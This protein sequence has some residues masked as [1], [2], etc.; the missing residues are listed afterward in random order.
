VKQL[1][2]L[3]HAK[4]SAESPQGTDFDRPLNEDGI[5]AAQFMGK[6]LA[7][8]QELPDLVCCSDS[9]RTRQTLLFV[10]DQLKRSLPVSYQNGLYLASAGD[11]LDYVTAI[12]EAANTVMLIGHNPGIYH[13][14]RILCESGDA[15]SMEALAVKF[16]TCAL[17]WIRFPDEVKWSHVA[18]N[19]G[20][21][22]A[23]WRPKILMRDK[24]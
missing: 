18:P 19:S 1:L 4:A 20:T 24:S 12:P 22:K 21:L 6:L 10:Q 15:E 23:F 9:A 5:L 16:P 11:L 17:A 14:A 8:Q 13:L 7:K 3:R 2:L